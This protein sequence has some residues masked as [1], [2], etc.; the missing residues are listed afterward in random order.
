M[1]QMTADRKAT[2]Q[3]VTAKGRKHGHAIHGQHSR[4]YKT[5]AS[6]KSRCQNPKAQGYEDYGGR[7]ITICDR[8]KGK[9]GFI[10]FLKDMG[11]RPA[12]Q[13]IDR[14]DVNGNYEPSNCRW[15]TLKESARNTRRNRFVI[16]Q[17]QRKTIA[18][19]AE[20]YG[21][22][23]YILFNR[24]RGGFSMEQAL[25]MPN[26]RLSADQV[27][28]VRSM[29]AAGMSQGEIGRRLHLDQATVSRI[30]HRLIYKHVE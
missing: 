26:R 30:K 8:W 23:H 1:I 27:R 11:P 15:A 7:G 21:L 5:W 28:E 4:E 14:I 18:E 10:E 17:G 20:I 24:L 13:V 22:P 2:G 16:F 9:N 19:W 6:M 3:I 29:L 12:G 25:T